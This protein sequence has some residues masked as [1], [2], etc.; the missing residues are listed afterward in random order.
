[1]QQDLRGSTGQS[2]VHRAGLARASHPAAVIYGISSTLHLQADT[3]TA[4]QVAV[5]Q[6]AL[7]DQ[8][9]RMRGARFELI[10][11][12]PGSEHELSPETAAL[13]VIKGS[14]TMG[15]KKGL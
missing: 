2:A 15:R 9:E 4:E 8:S 14:A 3:L 6:R 1:V 10:L 12:Q 13:W 11:P 5:L 7:H